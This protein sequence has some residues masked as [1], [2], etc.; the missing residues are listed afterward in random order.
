MI[1]NRRPR[2]ISDSVSDHREQ[3][4]VFLFVLFQ[5]L[6]RERLA[7]RPSPRLGLQLEL[8]LDPSLVE[9]G[10]GRGCCQWGEIV[11]PNGLDVASG[12]LLRIADIDTAGVDEEV[13]LAPPEN[14][15]PVKPLDTCGKARRVDG[16]GGQAVGREGDAA[17]ARPLGG[18][19]GHPRGTKERSEVGL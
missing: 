11:R 17:A 1:D 16:A 15:D 18:V 19:L 13:E 10:W 8:C 14:G 5:K 3:P 7:L 9:G 12:L 2:R 6:L 4:F